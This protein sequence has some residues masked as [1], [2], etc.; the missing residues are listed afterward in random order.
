[1]DPGSLNQTAGLQRN[2]GALGVEHSSEEKRGQKTNTT[3][4]T[5][6]ATV[7]NSW[8]MALSE[9]NCVL[10]S[11]GKKDK[12]CFRCPHGPWFQMWYSRRPAKGILGGA[13]LSEQ[14]KV[15]ELLTS[16]ANCL[17]QSPFI[18]I[19]KRLK[20]LFLPLWW[21]ENWTDLENP[22]LCSRLQPATGFSYKTQRK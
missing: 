18:T 16:L 20:K 7:C 5:T 13:L 19:F 1:M 6:E 22:I 14:V 8:G 12:M 21:S 10:A 4:E 17:T 3:T 11:L 2:W 15:S 9:A